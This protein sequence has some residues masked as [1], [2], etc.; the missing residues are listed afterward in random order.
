[1]NILRG[2]DG[3][4]EE[5]RDIEGFEGLYQ[6]SNM[7]RIKSLAR[8]SSQG[9][10]LP[11]RILS[12]AHAIS[13]Y[14]DVSLYKNGQRFHKKPHRL[15]AEAFIPNPENLPEV[16]HK[17]TNKDNN[18]VDNLRW[19]THAGNYENKLTRKRLSDDRI[20]KKL[21]EK[22]RLK[23][24]KPI[25]VIKDGK[26]IYTF[27]SFAQMDKQSKEIFGITLW[28]VYARQVIRGKLE[29]YH[30]FTFSYA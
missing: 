29:S 1:M 17:D 20:G 12:I 4:E 10:W 18:C 21:P 22:Q 9:H 30:G 16:D 25:N 14:T 26:I 11:E 5:W 24:C 8:Y 27:E 2:G 28:N 3:M 19:C 7:G 6:I 23:L 13:G 15:V